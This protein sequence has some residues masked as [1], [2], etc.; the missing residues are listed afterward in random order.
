MK[1]DSK[2]RAQGENNTYSG[3]YGK[4]FLNYSVFNKI[5]LSNEYI[6]PLMSKIFTSAK[7]FAD[8]VDTADSGI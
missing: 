6:C 3:I 4:I 8:F 2:S 5:V 1:E 7:R